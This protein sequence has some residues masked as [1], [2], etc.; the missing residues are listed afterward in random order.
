MSTTI[1]ER[2]IVL[3]PSGIE[4]YLMPQI[5]RSVKASFI[6]H[7]EGVTHLGNLAS[8]CKPSQKA[9]DVAKVQYLM[10]NSDEIG[11]VIVSKNGFI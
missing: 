10:D 3:N 2:F 7:F 11:I 6:K 8:I 4:R 5:K 9:V 1:N